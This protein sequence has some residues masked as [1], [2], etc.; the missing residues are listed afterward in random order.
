MRFVFLIDPRSLYTRLENIDSRF[1]LSDPLS[2]S[3]TLM[4]T[5]VLVSCT[6]FSNFDTERMPFGKCIVSRYALVVSF[7]L[8][9]NAL[10]VF[11]MYAATGRI[12]MGQSQRV[13]ERSKCI[14]PSFFTFLKMEY[15]AP[16]CWIR[17]SFLGSVICIFFILGYITIFPLAF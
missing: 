1:S 12:I 3:K 16:N 4:G 13:L 11:A 17:L 5:Y 7:S 8:G 15:S 14:S 2:R 9:V 6:Y 10:L